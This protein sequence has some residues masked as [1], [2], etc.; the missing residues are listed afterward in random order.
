MYECGSFRV[1]IA[2]K[3]TIHSRVELAYAL[4]FQSCVGTPDDHITP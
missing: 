4:I 3:K 1:S 2:K